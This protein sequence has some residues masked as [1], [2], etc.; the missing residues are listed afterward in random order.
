ME[1]DQPS[2]SQTTI[3]LPR[4]ELHF[5]DPLLLLLLVYTL[6]LSVN[7]ISM[8]LS[9][10]AIPSIALKVMGKAPPTRRVNFSSSNLF[11]TSF[12]VSRPIGC[13]RF[14]GRHKVWSQYPN[15]TI[16]T[17][18]RIYPNPPDG[19]TPEL[20]RKGVDKCLKSLGPHK[21]RYL[22]LHFPD[23]KCDLEKVLRVIDELHKENKLCVLIAE[24]Q[25]KCNS[26]QRR[27]RVEQL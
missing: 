25:S 5:L 22:Y 20:V 7:H 8:P 19:F 16:L 11:L 4:R 27:I 18:Y 12:T 3:E 15:L 2:S 10:T 21:I 13:Q 24:T 14:K 1:I 23:R 9:N 6:S 17:R 26:F